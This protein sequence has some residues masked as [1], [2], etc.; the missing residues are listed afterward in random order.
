M[1]EAIGARAAATRG[2]DGRAQ[3]ADLDEVVEVTGLER[4]VL[5]VVGE[6]Q[7]LA[8]AVGD[9]LDVLAG[10]GWSTRLRMRGRRAAAF[11]SKLAQLGEVG[12]LPEAVRDAAGRAEA[13]GRRE[14]GAIRS[15]FGVPAFVR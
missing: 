5:P 12:G 7:E 10:R 3:Q 9:A 13:E 11:R 14:E 2:I 4:G 1:G 6:A 15:L 8:G